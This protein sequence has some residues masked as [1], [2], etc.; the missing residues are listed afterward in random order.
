MPRR[1]KTPKPTPAVFQVS[2]CRSKKRFSNQLD[3]I[4]AAELKNLEDTTLE[5]TTYQCDT[6]KGWH[7]TRRQ[8]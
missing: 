4:R 5:L 8:Q 3:A 2:V 6:C 7:L 1:N